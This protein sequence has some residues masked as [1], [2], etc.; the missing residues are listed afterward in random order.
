MDTLTLTNP[1]FM[2]PDRPSAFTICGNCSGPVLENDGWK[3]QKC[4][5]VHKFDEYTRP[6]ERLKPCGH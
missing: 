2:T 3:C 4:G 6:I 1:V 5:V